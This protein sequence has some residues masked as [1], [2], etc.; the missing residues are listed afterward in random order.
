MTT[1]TIP[2]NAAEIDTVLLRSYAYPPLNESTSQFLRGDGTFADLPTDVSAH[3]STHRSGSTDALDIKN[4]DGWASYVFAD[5]TNTSYGLQNVVYPW[6]ALLDPE[7]S[8]IDFYLPTHRFKNLSFKRD[9]TGTIY[10]ISLYPGAGSVY[11]GQ[12]PFADL[13]RDT[14]SDSVPDCLEAAVNGSVTKFLE[15]YTMVI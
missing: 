8:I 6:I 5:S 7:T 11:H 10:S 1:H 9:E 3:E 12:I 13:T 14:N 4:L 15:N 2:L